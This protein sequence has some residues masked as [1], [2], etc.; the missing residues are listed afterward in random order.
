MYLITGLGN[1]GEKYLKSRHNAGFILLDEIV[2]DNWTDD[3]Y[4]KALISHADNQDREVLFVKPI[5][6][7]NN[8]GQSVKF[9]RD[10]HVVPPENIVVIH[11]DIDLPF[12]S[13]KLVFE[14]GDGG[15]NGIRSIINQLN[16]NKFIRIRVGIS[17]TDTEGRAVKPKGGF[18]TTPQK[19][20]SNYVLK[21]FGSSDLKKLKDM[22]PKVKDLLDTIIRDGY[23][24][25]MNKFN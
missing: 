6:F 17:P 15:H 4:A 11:D 9:L 7:M 10:K 18:F 5:T 14:R 16:T 25:A 20:V 23:M 12:G 2:G 3:K 21:D 24:G 13:V 8:S 1:P 22:A 19:A